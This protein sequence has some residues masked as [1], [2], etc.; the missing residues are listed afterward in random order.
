[1]TAAG[2]TGPV[3]QPPT[4]CSVSGN[5]SAVITFNNNSSSVSITPVWIDY[6]CVEQPYSS[7]APGG[8]QAFSSYVTHPWRIRNSA[9]NAL[10]VE[11]PPLTGDTTVNFP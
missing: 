7:I 8:S 6:S 10:L 11:I 9:T 3:D 5:K 1:M 2:G 4:V